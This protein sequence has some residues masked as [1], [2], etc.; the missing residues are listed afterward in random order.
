MSVAPEWR[1]GVSESGQTQE[2]QRGGRGRCLGEGPV[3]AS[4]RV[5]AVEGPGS[6]H[7]SGVLEVESTGLDLC[8]RRG[9]LGLGFEQLGKQ[10]PHFL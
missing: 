4:M 2:E 9:F 1:R 7:V 10:W 8:K 5:V 6:G 3:M